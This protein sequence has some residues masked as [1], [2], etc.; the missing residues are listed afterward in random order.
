MSP[1]H[2]NKVNRRAFLTASAMIG[3]GIAL[4][5][6]SAPVLA[7][8]HNMSPGYSGDIIGM[9][10][11]ELSAAIKGRAVSCV[12]VMTA[13]LAHIDRYNPAVNAII[14]RSDQDILL[15]EAR[16]KDHDLA[17]GLY[18][19][20]MHGFPHAVK[21][22][23]HIKGHRTVSGSPIFKDYVAE[24]DS[25]FV[26]RIRAAGAIFIGKT[27][28]P[29][30]GLGSQSYN[31]V[32]GATGSAYDPTKT[33]GGS[34]GGASCGLAMKMLPVADGSDMMGSLR[35]PA[36]YNNIIG[37]RPSLGRVPGDDNF[38][39]QL[40]CSGPMGRNV[41]DTAKLLSTMAG[42]D[43]R[44]P[45]SLQD[46]PQQFARP[47]EKDMKGVRVGWL[48]DM[49]GYYPMEKGV[50]ELCQKAMTHFSDIG[51]EVTEATIDYDLN[52]L[53]KSWKILRHW[54]MDGR[55]GSFY[56]NPQTRDLLKPE[57]IWE[58]ENGRKLS[59]S[60]VYK[61]TAARAD[62]YNAI[63]QAFQ[64]HD[65][66]V[67][68]TAQVF[69]FDKNIHW[70]KTV[71]GRAMD[72]YHRWMEIVVPGTMSGCPVINVPVGF[73]ENGLPM[74]IQIIGPS[75]RDF[76]VLQIAYAY[77]QAARWNYDYQPPALKI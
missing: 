4:S 36:A 69:P 39:Q 67:I 5:G 30:F 7:N 71:A 40:A 21:D 14:L 2:R 20:W 1:D 62:F 45:L 25:I 17:N 61:A 51:C 63:A 46:D 12:E 68:P 74:G 18:H 73:N 60:D 56:D 50:L 26:E 72:T 16:Q 19:G 48:G 27:N 35:N 66:L 57:A 31:S 42:H 44:S 6:F 76:E 3:T 55:L 33:A 23:A 64:R 15:T 28:V 29:E 47:L 37:F 34:S 32:F 24:K 11:L 43:P 13:Y 41:A 53:W 38:Y 49:K 70:P 54:W 22:L 75:G 10:A 8:Y 9:T 65:F 77:E 59:G 52:D 58:I